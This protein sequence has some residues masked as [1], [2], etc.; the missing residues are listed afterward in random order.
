MSYRHNSYRKLS[1]AIAKANAQ[2]AAGGEPDLARFEMN[3]VM[4]WSNRPALPKPEGWGKAKGR[5]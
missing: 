3:R 2:T 4:H 5:R 1:K